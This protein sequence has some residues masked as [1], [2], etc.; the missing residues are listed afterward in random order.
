MKTARTVCALLAGLTAWRAPAQE[1]GGQPATVAPDDFASYDMLD[2]D[3]GWATAK[4]GDQAALLQTRDGGKSWTVIA[5]KTAQPK[6]EDPLQVQDSLFCHLLDP[7]HGWVA[8]QQVGD[9]QLGEPSP[10]KPTLFSTDDGGRTWKRAAFQTSAGTVRFVQ[11]SDPLHGFLLVE[12]NVLAEHTRKEVHRT[13]D[14]GQKWRKTAEAVHNLVTEN[15]GLPRTDSVKGLVFRNGTDGWINGEPRGLEQMFLLRTRDAGKTWRPLWFDPPREF[16]GPV[17]ESGTPQF[18][19]EGK[20]DGV[21]G[22][23]FREYNPDHFAYAIYRTRDGGERWTCAG[24]APEPAWDVGASFV[25]ADH[26][27]VIAGDKLFAT[28]DGGAHWEKLATNLRFNGADDDH[29]ENPQALRFVNAHVGWVVKSIG[30]VGGR[31]ELLRTDDGGHTWTHR[32]GPP[33]ELAPP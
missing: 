20:S 24:F 4:V 28:V 9:D 29:H 17:E 6:V 14:G 22:V 30:A 13:E 16:L 27:W 32:C 12:S 11:F 1:P 10:W 33:G 21:L 8:V 7:D 31:S 23:L 15:G 2:A 3:T 25:D 26:G 19:G 5:P 18:F